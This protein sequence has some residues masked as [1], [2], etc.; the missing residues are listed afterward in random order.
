MSSAQKQTHACVLRLPPLFVAA[1]GL[2]PIGQIEL[3]TAVT[4]EPSRGDQLQECLL[5]EL[6][7]LTMAWAIM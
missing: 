3:V 1:V 4:S 6:T 7:C 2:L 5:L